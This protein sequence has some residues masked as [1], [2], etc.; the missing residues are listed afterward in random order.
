MRQSREL[1]FRKGNILVGD[2]STFAKFFPLSALEAS[3]ANKCFAG[4]IHVLHDE[5][6][7]NSQRDD[8]EPSVVYN[9]MKKSLVIVG[10][11]LLTKNIDVVLL[12]QLQHLRTYLN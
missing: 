9:E 12:K 7:P 4:E 1:G 10:L 11:V 5:L 2:N 8:F 6:I 3:R